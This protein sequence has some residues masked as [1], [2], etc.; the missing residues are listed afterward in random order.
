MRSAIVLDRNAAR[1]P[2]S[3]GFSDISAGRLLSSWTGQDP[4]MSKAAEMVAAAFAGGLSWRGSLGGKDIYCP[5][6]GMKGR[7]VMIGFKQFLAD[8]PEMADRP[9]GQAMA[10]SLIREFPCQAQ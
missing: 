7:D 3:G 5:V 6:S 4:M 8:H 2:G 1:A 10:A 9:Y